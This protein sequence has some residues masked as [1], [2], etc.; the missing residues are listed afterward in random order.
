VAIDILIKFTAILTL[1]CGRGGGSLKIYGFYEELVAK[2]LYNSKIP[3][4]SSVGHE[5]DFTI[6]I[7]RQTLRAATPSV[8]AEIK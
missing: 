3:V 2:G 7:L 6:A 5:V 8:A 4:I 1:F